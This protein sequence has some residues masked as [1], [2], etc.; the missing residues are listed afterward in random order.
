VGDPQAAVW[1]GDRLIVLVANRSDASYPTGEGVAL[2]LDPGTG[3]WESLPPTHVGERGVDLAWD[4]EQVVAVDY[5]MQ[6]ATWRPGDDRWRPLPQVPLR[7]S[8]CSPQLAAVGDTV[9]AVHCS[10]E[11]LL[12]EDRQWAIAPR[13]AEGA[14]GAAVGT[15]DALLIWRS[16]DYY[17]DPPGSSLRSYRPPEVPEDDL[18]LGRTVPIGTVLLDLPPGSRLVGTD[19]IEDA[20]GLVTGLFFDLA[21]P[22]CSLAST[23]AGSAGPSEVRIRND[24]ERVGGE[25]DHVRLPE[26]DIGRDRALVARFEQGRIDEEAHIL[27]E[28]STSDVL[29][30]ACDD[31][32]TAEAL[33]QGIHR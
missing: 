1:A 3:T 23:Y 4:G 33:L 22:D 18:A 2:A 17:G 24:V 29:D 9:L 30:I 7:F 15:G 25:L 10:G 13:A 16:S 14:L 12:T 5:E 27:L 8:E 20:G 31:L 28:E 26:V 19:R 6:A 32:S 21:G 11:A